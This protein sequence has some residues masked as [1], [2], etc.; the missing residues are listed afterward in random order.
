MAID[1]TSPRTRRTVLLG[2]LGGAVAAAAATVG[3]GDPV[4]AA[5][6]DFVRIGGTYKATNVTEIFTTTDGESAF[7]GQS[8]SGYGLNGASGS[9]WGV[10][11]QS[12]TAEGVSGD[13]G[14]GYGVQ[15]ISNKLTGV[16][17]SGPSSGVSGTS[18][19]GYGV[20]GESLETSGVYGRSKGIGAGVNGQS[21]TGYGVYAFSD[22]GHAVHAGSNSE[23][24]VYGSSGS[25]SVPAVQG[26]SKGGNTGLQGFSG[27]TKP[28]ASPRHT[29][30][31][32]SANHDATSAGVRG[33]SVTG[34]GGVFA[35]KLAQLRLKPSAAAT[36]PTRGATGDLFV[37]KPGRL[38]FCTKG[39]PS[40]TW[41]RV[42]LV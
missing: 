29:G 36:H 10:R 4:S 17:G 6:G 34:R 11:G 32:G 39:G 37:D 5:D 13:S 18:T 12:D 14:Q 33:V 27:T 24:G 20:Y 1:T 30:I 40:A 38:W 9:S 19:S 25:S 26:W 16:F 8:V 21:T 3:R 15:G 41:K 23:I 22:S 7:R 28:P 2:A 42:A 31:F 35:G